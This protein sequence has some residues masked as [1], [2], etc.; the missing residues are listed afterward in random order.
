MPWAHQL[1]AHL[2]HLGRAW[3]PTCMPACIARRLPLQDLQKLAHETSSKLDGKLQEQLASVQTQLFEEKKQRADAEAEA[4]VRRWCHVSSCVLSAGL[5][6]GLPGVAACTFP[7]HAHPVPA[8][9]ACCSTSCFDVFLTTIR[10]RRPRQSRCGERWSGCSAAWR[11]V[12]HS[13]SSSR[14]RA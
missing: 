12:S 13:F 11:R 7:T 4:Q 3:A 1:H 14:R 8:S 6:A 9:C 10:S 5:N 2:C